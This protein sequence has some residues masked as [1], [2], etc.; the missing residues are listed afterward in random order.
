M[1]IEDI[2]VYH[3]VHCYLTALL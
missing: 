1:M 2:G 3:K